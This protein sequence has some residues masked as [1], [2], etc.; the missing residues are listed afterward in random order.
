VHLKRLPLA[1]YAYAGLSAKRKLGAPVIAQRNMKTNERTI[2][3]CLL[4]TGL[5]S[6]LIS[7][8]GPGQL[9]GPTLTPTATFTSTPTLTPT[10]T[11]TPTST[12]TPTPTPTP[13]G[14]ILR[15]RFLGA[16][17][18]KPV[19]KS[20]IILCLIISENSCAIKADLVT[21]TNKN[22]EFELTSVPA[23]LYII[24]HSL[25]GKA[26][27]SYSDI[28]GAEVGME[29]GKAGTVF[30]S[31]RIT[32]NISKGNWS[33]VS[34]DGGLVLETYNFRRTSVEIQ[35]EKITIIEFMG[36]TY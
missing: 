8:C 14:G 29:L 20:A 18:Y 6:L 7:S 22:G 27:S 12:L 1:R 23:G 5:V 30:N 36:L 34:K 16:G 26:R 9:L 25:P 11:F 24:L 28:D 32:K 35:P 21:I 31:A 19:A 4:A 13:S 10:A 33:T 3:I 15:G 2:L 17:N